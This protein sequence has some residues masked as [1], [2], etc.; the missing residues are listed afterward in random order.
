MPSIEMFR[1]LFEYDYWGNRQALASLSTL[2]SNNGAG[3][4][5]VK[6]F[7]HII[8]A[9]RI[10]LARLEQQH[11]SK[12]QS[13]PALTIE[14]CS[15]GVEET[16]K[17]WTAHLKDWTAEDRPRGVAYPI[18]KGDEFRTPL[19]DILMHVIMHSVYHRGQVAAAVREAGGKAVPTDFAVW[20]RQPRAS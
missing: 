14:Q 11:L 6:L 13:I 4:R 12:F 19:Q 1:R 20:I 3:E 2:P 16:N 8:G 7:G 9:Q 10:W 18:S 5:A 17:R 15:E